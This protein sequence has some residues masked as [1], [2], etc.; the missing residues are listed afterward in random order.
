MSS[1]VSTS[2]PVPSSLLSY[3]PALSGSSCLSLPQNHA[4][5]FHFHLP[6]ALAIPCHLCLGLKALATKCDVRSVLVCL[7]Q[8]PSLAS[9]TTRFAPAF[10]D[11]GRLKQKKKREDYLPSN[12]THARVVVSSLL[13][14]LR[15]L[16]LKSTHRHKHHIKPSSFSC[17]L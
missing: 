13:R 12:G 10:R 9:A 4:S 5:S 1:S 17:C 6:L 3:L 15:T 14:M 11:A 16:F 7:N 2:F 8:N